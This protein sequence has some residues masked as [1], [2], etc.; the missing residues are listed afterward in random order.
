MQNKVNVFNDK[1]KLLIFDI[2][3][4]EIEDAGKRYRKSDREKGEREREN[5]K[6][7]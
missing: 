2:Y 7:R 1:R 6:K 4:R 5:K 3:S